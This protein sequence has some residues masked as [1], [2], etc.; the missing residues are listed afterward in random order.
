MLTLVT[1]LGV[2]GREDT[3]VPGDVGARLRHALAGRLPVR[4]EG[5]RVP[6]RSVVPRA[7][8]SRNAVEVRDLRRPP[9]P[10]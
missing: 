2:L 8:V 1:A 6:A 10:V 3:A 4:C 5:G 7:A 9:E